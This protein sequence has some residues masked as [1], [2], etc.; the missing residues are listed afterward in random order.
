MKKFST[1]FVAM[2]IASALAAQVNLMDGL[3]AWYPLD[4]NANDL[5]GNNNHGIVN[6]A[7]PTT[8]RFGNVNSAM[9]FAGIANPQT[10]FVPNSPSL[11]FSNQASISLWVHM[12][13]Y[14]GMNNFGAPVTLGTHV[15]WSKDD[16]GGFYGSVTGQSSSKFLVHTSPNGTGNPIEA[17]EIVPCSST[18]E[19]IHLV[20]VFYPYETRIYANGVMIQR[21]YGVNLFNNSQ[22]KDLWFG[23]HK[24]FWYPLNGKLDDIRIYNRPLTEDEV[25]VLYSGVNAPSVAEVYLCG[26]GSATLT[27]TGAS[28]GQVYHWYETDTS[29]TPVAYGASFT[30]PIL[31]QLHTYYVT[32]EQDGLESY[33][34]AAPVIISQLPADIGQFWTLTFDLNTGLVAWYPLDG[35]ANDASNNQNNG[36]AYN[37]LNGPNPAGQSNSAMYFNGSNAWIEVP[38][39]PSL[40]SPTYE[41]TLTA[42][43]KS[44]INTAYFLCKVNGQSLNSYQYRTGIN[45]NNDTY[46]LG[47]NGQ[48]YNSGSNVPIPLNEWF[49]YAVTYDGDSI[50][51]YINGVLS[52]KVKQPGTIIPNEERLEIGRDAYGQIEWLKGWLDEVRIYNRALSAAEIQ[53]L[54]GQYNTLNVNLIS[55]TVCNGNSAH[56][57]IINSQ[58]NIRYTLYAD[59]IPTNQMVYGNGQTVTLTSQSL[60]ETTTF[61]IE[62]LDESTGCSRILSNTWTVNVITPQPSITPAYTEICSGNSVTLTASGGVSYLW[63]TGQTTPSIT[64]SPTV[65]TTYTV[66]VTTQEGCIGTATA[67]V[68][69]HPLPNTAAWSNSPV[70]ENHM[71]NLYASGGEIYNWTGPNGF[72]SNLQNPTIPSVSILN[73]G[74]YSVTVIDTNGCS[75]PDST[76]VNIFLSF[77][78]TINPYICEGQSYTLPGGMV[79]NQTG[80]YIDTIPAHNGCDSIIT[81]NL[82]VR[83]LPEITVYSNSPVCAGGTL[84][85]G[86]SAPQCTFLWLGPNGFISTQPQ[87]SIPNA[88]PSNAGLYQV[89]ATDPWGCISSAMLQAEIIKIES[90]YQEID[91]CQGDHYTLP[92]GSTVYTSGIYYDTLAS[93]Q[94][95][96]SAIITKVTFH[97]TPVP[98]I[99]NLSTDFCEHHTL[100]LHGEGGSNYSWTLPT[101]DT[102]HGQDLIIENASVG[103]FGWYHLTVSNEY[104]CS[105]STMQ[106][107]M[108]LPVTFTHNQ[109][110]LCPGDV[111]QLP[112]GKYISEPGLYIDTIQSQWGCDSIIYSEIYA[113]E[114]PDLNLITNS[115]VCPGTMAYI[116][117]SG[118]DLFIWSGPGGFVSYESKIELAEATSE[119]AGWYYVT[120][121]DTLGCFAIDSIYL[122]VSCEGTSEI[123]GLLAN[124]H[125][126]PFNNQLKVQLKPELKGE[127]NIF[128]FDVTGKEMYWNVFKNIPEIEINL[129]WLKPGTYILEVRNAR[130]VSRVKVIK[131]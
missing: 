55:S 121:I 131:I 33:K 43:I 127:S 38:N 76:Y 62:A 114:I 95:C 5:S 36:T 8:D 61:S 25:H 72:A 124:V 12:N 81:I 70:C 96:D 110:G 24:A 40:M 119:D 130:E 20:F 14:Y 39:S 107:V 60:S 67:Q 57:Q 44:E 97:A 118:A 103:Y 71:L 113:K 117:A 6:G 80:T 85:I 91:L 45:I 98:S 111:Y 99:Y 69:V 29:C 50:R 28:S 63:S 87:F 4:G 15:L 34:V 73:A 120:G 31:S 64:V 83:P 94:S 52:S 37:L 47:F 100:H 128:V 59:G 108:I 27:A 32:I 109:A 42:W 125:P 86:A 22:N 9:N 92:G 26:P 48:D 82:T 68:V 10:I 46:Y 56:F 30:T 17:E 104:N 93:Y 78:S 75:A 65:N 51:F 19:W 58:P 16:A 7:T 2:F 13:S 102:I 79:V 115:P 101:G 89:A 23:R 106:F 35:N 90:T 77:Y 123:Q 88:Q 21:N 18:Q 112:S 66:T 84:T 49:H 53:N 41:L 74:W 1:L 116:E 105:A 54:A 126:N 3:V 11:N 122:M 129:G